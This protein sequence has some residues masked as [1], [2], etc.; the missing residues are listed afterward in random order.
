MLEDTFGGLSTGG[1]IYSGFQSRQLK[2]S[3]LFPGIN[4]S[5]SPVVDDK[6]LK[7]S[8]YENSICIDKFLFAILNKFDLLRF[9]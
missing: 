4:R 6:F 7:C 8:F 1:A 5:T 2:G 9:S 3:G